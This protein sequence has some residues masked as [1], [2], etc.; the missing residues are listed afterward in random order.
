MYKHPTVKETTLIFEPDQFLKFSISDDHIFA[1]NNFSGSSYNNFINFEQFYKYG[2]KALEIRNDKNNY[3]PDSSAYNAIGTKKFN[4]LKIL[5]PSA[6]YGFSTCHDVATANWDQ[7]VSDK[8][9]LKEALKNYDNRAYTLRFVYTRLPIKSAKEFFQTCLEELAKLVGI[10]NVPIV[11]DVYVGNKQTNEL[12][13]TFD[14]EWIKTRTQAYMILKF[15]RTYSEYHS[16][17]N[18]DRTSFYNNFLRQNNVQD[19]SDY[20]YSKKIK[21]EDILKFLE[22]PKEQLVDIFYKNYKKFDGS[23]FVCNLFFPI[24]YGLLFDLYTCHKD[25]IMGTP[26]R[27]HKLTVWS[28]HPSHAGLRGLDISKPTT[29]RFGYRIKNNDEKPKTEYSI[30]SVEAIQNSASKFRMKQKFSENNV[31]TGDWVIPN[32]EQ[33]L[34]DFCDKYKESKFIVKSEMGS[35]G[36][37]LVLFNN[38][39]EVIKWFNTPYVKLNKKKYGNYLVE[40]YYNFSREYRLHVNKYGCF[41]TCRKMLRE[42]AENRWYRNDDNC[43]WIVEENDMFQKPLNWDKI[44]AE[45]VNA[46]NA[47]GLDFG[48]CDVLVQAQRNNKQEIRKDPDFIICE[49]NSAPG[50]GNVGLEV[51]KKEIRNYID[52]L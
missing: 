14:K 9:L 47:V 34:S 41:Y 4:D 3:H 26:K 23:Q 46:L 16:S 33:E 6:S 12:H 31:K 29:I 7:Y 24:F 13:A 20:V 10:K 40:K 8:N 15:M 49:I 17:Y 48:A 1:I 32:N 27:I 51:Y 21:E 50:L 5:Y 36:E 39:E 22:R 2:E 43:V 52:K 11:Y 38:K 42:D 45:C 44:V 19:L 30:N 18:S 35:R 37:G 25:E 28:R